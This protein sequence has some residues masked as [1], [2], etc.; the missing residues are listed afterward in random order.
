MTVNGIGQEVASVGDYVKRIVYKYVEWRT[1][2]RFLRISGVVVWNPISELP[3][4]SFTATVRPL[5]LAMDT[6][7]KEPLPISLSIFKSTLI[8]WNAR[9]LWLGLQTIHFAT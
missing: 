8:T 3:F 5:H 9:Q 4:N 1:F 7:P 6:L 2:C